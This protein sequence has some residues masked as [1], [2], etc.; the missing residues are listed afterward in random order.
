[1]R[2]NTYINTK[3]RAGERI[4]NPKAFVKGLQKY[5]SDYYDKEIDAKKSPK[6]K[7]TWKICLLCTI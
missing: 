4:G 7:A 3:V 1:M 6:G 5:L 2:V